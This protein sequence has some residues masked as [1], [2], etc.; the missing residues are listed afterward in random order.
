MLWIQLLITVII[1]TLIL[2][3]AS[4]IKSHRHTHPALYKNRFAIWSIVW[5]ILNF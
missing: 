5:L 4:W 3:G 2:Q 1:T